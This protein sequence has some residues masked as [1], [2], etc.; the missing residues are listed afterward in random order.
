M[1]TRKTSKAGFQW[2]PEERDAVFVAMRPFVDKGLTRGEAYLKAQKVALPPDRRRGLPASGEISGGVGVLYTASRG[3]PEARCQEIRRTFYSV[4]QAQ[5]QV[6]QIEE[7]VRKGLGAQAAVDAL[8]AAPA[9]GKPAPRTVQ[10]AKKHWTPLEWALIARRVRYWQKDMGSNQS[11]AVLC[12]RAQKLELP[13]ERRRPPT[14]FYSSARIESIRAALQAGEKAADK[15]LADRPLRYGA[16]EYKPVEGDIPVQAPTPSPILEKSPTGPILALA[17][18]PAAL[19]SLSGPALAFAQSVGASLDKLLADQ[20][21]QHEAQ[22][23]EALALVAERVEAKLKPAFDAQ[24]VA[25]VSQL[26]AGM[27]TALREVLIAEIGGPGPSAKPAETAEA[28]AAPSAANGAANGHA[29]E[30][31]QAPRKIP[32][33]VV[34]LNTMDVARSIERSHGESFDFRW[35]NPDEVNRF[36]PHRGRQCLMLIQR[37]PHALKEKARAAGVKPLMIKHTEGHI[38]HALDELLRGRG[39]H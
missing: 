25:M 16:T 17:P 31:V 19:G 5:E 20:Q 12:I 2:R 3:W 22:L 8:T 32:V 26:E 4:Q 29:L 11:L 18:A 39:L 21:R 6:G 15:L 9:A 14:S 28:P 1:A 38:T 23:G 24:F 7:F 35:I 37:V 36:A 13:P 30:R 27:R 34:G 33:D 10:A